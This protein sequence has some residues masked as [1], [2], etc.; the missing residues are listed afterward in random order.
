MKHRNV[1]RVSFGA[2]VVLSVVAVSAIAILATEVTDEQVADY[3]P[4][5]NGFQPVVPMRAYPAY[6]PAPLLGTGPV[7]GATLTPESLDVW[8]SPGES[9]VEDKLLHIPKEQ[10]PTSADILIC[11]DLTGS[12]GGELHQVKIHAIDIM[13][14]VRDLVSDTRFGVISHM[15]YPGSYSGCRYGAQYGDPKDGDLPYM[16][17]RSLTS[18]LISVHN[19]INALSLGDGSDAPECYS[20]ALYETYMD[21]RIGW[22]PDA[23]KIVVQWGDNVPHDCNYGLCIG[24]SGTTGPDPGRDAIA[25]NGDDLNIIDVVDA[26]DDNHITLVSMYS[27]LS[28]DK[29]KLWNCLAGRTG[30]EAFE[31]NTDGTVVGDVDI[32]DYIVGAI[33]EQFKEIDYLTLQVCDPEYEDWLIDVDPD[34]YT[35]VV[36]DEDHDFEFTI[37]LRVPEGTEPGDYCF[38]ICAVGDGAVYAR[39][40][41]CIHVRPDECF[42][43]EIGHE[44]GNAGELVRV[45]V[46]IQ[47]ATG[48]GIHLLDI[49]ICW[50]PDEEGPLSLAGFAAGPVLVANDLEVNAA[51]SGRN[52]LSFVGK[53]DDPLFGG[54]TLFYIDFAISEGA[55]PC[56]CCDVIFASITFDNSE[57]IEICPEDGSVCLEHCQIDGYVHNWYCDDTGGGPVLTDP[58][59]GVEMN[60]YKIC[61]GGDALPPGPIATAHTDA[62]GYYVFDCIAPLDNPREAMGDFYCEYCIEP[63]DLEIPDG[64]ITAYDASLILKYYDSLISLDKC[65]FEYDGT[66]A[67]PQRIAGDVNCEG[68]VVELDAELVLQYVVDLIGTF[69]CCPDWVWVPKRQCTPLCPDALDFIGVLKG[70]VSGPMPGPVLAPAHMKVG[71]P[72]HYNDGATGYVDI[73]IT[74]QNVVD[75]SGIEFLLN[76]NS[77]KLILLSVVPSG[78]TAGYSVAYKDIGGAVDVA[79]AGATSFS[80]NGRIA[81]V[82]FQKTNGYRPPVAHPEVSLGEALFNE[83]DPPAVI[84]GHSYDGEIWRFGLGPVTPNPFSQTTTITYNAPSAADVSLRI[85][86]VHGQVVRNVF[87]GQVAAGVHQVAWDGRDDSGRRVARGIYFCRF[88]AGGASA[89][90]KLV[91]LK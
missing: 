9:I 77:D 29:L 86:N 18:D 10:L 34:A 17:N 49:D 57:Y 33:G 56:D 43:M 80:G 66:T 74:V 24:L 23:R 51:Q 50:C 53:T 38:E 28:M 19:T 85:F 36:L 87:S 35:N 67:Y 63:G 61:E 81:M 68:S 22:R 8:L 58:L 90:E 47:D 45:P 84:D 7:L 42:R 82:K 79:L 83:G 27:G 6:E 91:L 12:M 16:L 26:M 2:L 21:G 37:T 5:G 4:D 40:N 14:G 32:T 44:T 76:F 78:R 64:W 1:N 89:T 55:D 73:P 75:V 70:D 15:D 41:V 62:D 13:N 3:Q 69:P 71:I 65:P 11:F 31:L 46:N 20:R 39:Q 48:W 88:D 72:R 25:G 30:G 60:I 52:C 54:G 59:E